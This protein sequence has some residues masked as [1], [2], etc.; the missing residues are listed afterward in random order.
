MPYSRYNSTS[1]MAIKRALNSLQVHS[2]SSM[3]SR[4]RPTSPGIASPRSP[5]PLSFQSPSTSSQQQHLK[6]AS[7]SNLRMDTLD[8]DALISIDVLIVRDT[9]HMLRLQQFLGHPFLTQLPYQYR[10]LR[11]I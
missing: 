4:G 10:A 8:P 6:R 9:I 3:A 7:S 11:V 2:A 5:D 1:P